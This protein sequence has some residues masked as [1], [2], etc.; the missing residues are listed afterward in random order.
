MSAWAVGP[1]TLYLG[2]T[3]KQT[4]KSWSVATVI[5]SVLGW[6]GAVVLSAVV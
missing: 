3:E 6:A 4:L 2:M 5:I 1:I